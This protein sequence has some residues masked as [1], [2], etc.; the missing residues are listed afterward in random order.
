MRLDERYDSMSGSAWPQRTFCYS[1]CTSGARER[2]LAARSVERGA[3]VP[4]FIWVDGPR[5]VRSLQV[6]CV[7]ER[8]DRHQSSR[9]HPSLGMILTGSTRQAGGSIPPETANKDIIVEG[10]S[11]STGRSARNR[12]NETRITVFCSGGDGRVSNP[13][14]PARP[15]NV[16]KFKRPA[17]FTAS[18]TAPPSQP[19]TMAARPVASVLLLLVAVVLALFAPVAEGEHWRKRLC[20][21]GWGAGQAQLPPRGWC[22]AVARRQALPVQT[23]QGCRRHARRMRPQRHAA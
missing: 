18:R 11:G 6:I 19:N 20:M 2:T 3:C 10:K 5:T 9:P 15:R 17:S 4:C 22:A 12:A 14:K 21:G 13:L 16:H 7:Q 23:G 1:A 8:S